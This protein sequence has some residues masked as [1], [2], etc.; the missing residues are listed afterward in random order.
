MSVEEATA[1][2]PAAGEEVR[3]ADADAAP[4]DR[5]D[6]YIPVRRRDIIEALLRDGA[7]PEAETEDFRRFCNILSAVFHH[8]YHDELETLRDRYFYF[9]P[10]RPPLTFDHIDTAQALGE[11]TAAFEVAMRAANFVEISP[12]EIAEAERTAALLT[13]ET[14]IPKDEYET[15][16]FFRRGRHTESGTRASW[17]GLKREKISFDVYENV[18]V[19]IAMKNA[20]VRKRRFFGEAKSAVRPGSVLIKY[21]TNIPKPD[22]NM[23]FPGVRVV[24]SRVDQALLGIPALLGGVPLLLNAI[25]AL[26]VL[27]V[28][29]GAYLGLT[30]A[31][32]GDRLKQALAAMS[33]LVALGGFLM[34]QWMSYERKSLKYQQ[35]L[36]QHI[37]YRNENNNAGIFDY[38]I[39][40]AEEQEIKEAL[41]AYYVLNAAAEPLPRE[42]LDTMIEQWL[43][44]NFGVDID[45]EIGDALAKLER[46]NLL[47]RVDGGLTVIPITDAL[48]AL[49]E[50]WDRFYEYPKPAAP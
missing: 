4:A 18:V 19:F 24:M 3:G 28:V 2:G 5:R 43:A 49:D 11:L 31:I 44:A 10:A 7:A 39:G 48:A 46:L 15:V 14:K 27:A 34:R 42:Q 16:R 21:F 12:D 20:A 33:G 22:L 45:F 13:V 25:P 6:Q 17:Y 9:D 38:L 50:I 37:Y 41:L 32:E 26:S 47:K 8:E 23:L 1:S 40:Q 35:A 30:G 36:A 29:A